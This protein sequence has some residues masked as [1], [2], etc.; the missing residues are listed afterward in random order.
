MH[1]VPLSCAP[2][3]ASETGRYLGPRPLR[4]VVVDDE[5]DSVMTLTML[6]NDEGHDVVGLQRGSEVLRAVEEFKP[7]AVLL[8][9][10]M[11]DMS[12]YEVAKEIRRRYGEARPLLIAISGRY[13]KASDKMLAEIVGFNHHLA[14]PYEPKELLSL[15]RL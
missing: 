15:L 5:P 13:K 11:P 7:D 1:S 2:A 3:H 12:G 8:D 6:L 9:I 4:I 14:K 10:A